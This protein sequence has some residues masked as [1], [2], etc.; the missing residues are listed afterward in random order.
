MTPRQA[1]RCRCSDAWHGQGVLW[2]IMLMTSLI[3]PALLVAMLVDRLLGDPDRIWRRVPHPV[4]LIG[5][6][7]GWLERR[8]RPP[9]EEAGWERDHGERL[10][11]RGKRLVLILV[12][13]ALVLGLV[14]QLALLALPL[15]W[16]WLGI[17]MST[18]LAQKSLIDH[19]RAVATGLA[20]DVET[21]REA[22][23]HIVGRDA[24]ALDA[25][26]IGRA[27]T[28][29]LAE[30]LSDGVIAPIFWALLL[31]LPGLLAYKAINTADSMIG[32]LNER[33]Q[34]FGRAAARLDDA[35][36]LVP[37]RLTAVMC[38][39][40]APGLGSPWRGVRVIRRDSR[41]HRSPNAG[42]PEAAMAGI[43]GLKLSGPRIYHGVGTDEPW[44]GDGN[45]DVGSD[46]IATALRLADRVWALALVLVVALWIVT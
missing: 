34:D 39:L 14:L 13:G 1:H 9:D 44:V 31:G 7:I 19:V 29:S 3:F 25:A 43:L 27:A 28:E 8:L 5:R 24:T 45:P 42:W 32:Y 38:V 21:G 12:G 16:L 23:A 30:N 36:N 46:E 4:V 33:Y 15:G 37:A 40:T 6:S 18:L 22:V 2:S 10:R 35:V 11:Q 17:V 41:L 20:I 26:A